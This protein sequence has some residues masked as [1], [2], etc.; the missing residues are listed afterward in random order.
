MALLNGTANGLVV[1]GGIVGAQTDKGL[2][3]RET[4]PVRKMGI[5]QGTGPTIHQCRIQT[6]KT[7][8]VLDVIARNQF[9]IGV[10]ELDTCLFEGALCEK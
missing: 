2:S 7:L 3:R 9:V 10:K 4:I 1:V 5:D 8:T 6:R